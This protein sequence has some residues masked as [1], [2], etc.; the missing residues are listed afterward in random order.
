MAYKV[1]F[2]FSDGS[3]SDDLLDEVFETVDD[4]E[5]EAQQAA[6]DYSQGRDYLIEA[7][8]DYCEEDIDDWDIVEI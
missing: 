6:S 8:E 2:N 4:A 7:G 1:V 3:S 5:E